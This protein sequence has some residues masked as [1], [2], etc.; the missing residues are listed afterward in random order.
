MKKCKNRAPSSLW[1][2]GGRGHRGAGNYNPR[3]E[4]VQRLDAEG[5]K[6]KCCRIS[7]G[8]EGDRSWIRVGKKQWCGRRTRNWESPSWDE[9]SRQRW[10]Q[11]SRRKETAPSYI[12]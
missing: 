5:N 8:F 4:A 9:G 2:R 7:K 10:C 6:E 1:R 3:G 11:R 12:R